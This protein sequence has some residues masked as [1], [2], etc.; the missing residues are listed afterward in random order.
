MILTVYDKVPEDVV[1]KIQS[2]DSEHISDYFNDPFTFTVG[3]VHSD[4]D[5]VAVGI[6]RVVSEYK[7]IVNPT[8]SNIHKAA[9]IKQLF[10]EAIHRTKCNEV[11]VI[12]TKGGQEYEE[13]L[14][15]HFGFE[16]INGTPMRLEK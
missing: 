15:K 1:K 4:T 14:S 8:A 11:L 7:I 13:L 5:T 16:K 9:A 3:V 12:I 2:F 10:I 6:I